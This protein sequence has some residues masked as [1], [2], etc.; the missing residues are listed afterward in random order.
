MPPAPLP[1]Q[2]PTE[3]SPTRGS[4]P[5]S[6]RLPLRPGPGSWGKDETDG[7][8]DSP[9]PL[10]ATAARHS[11]RPP[12]PQ[13][14]EDRREPSTAHQRQRG[15]GLATRSSLL[16]GLGGKKIKIREEGRSRAAPSGAEPAPGR[17][18]PASGMSTVTHCQLG[19][20]FPC[21][22]FI[23]FKLTNN[24]DKTGSSKA[25]FFFFSSFSFASEGSSDIA[26]THGSAR[27][28]PARAHAR[29]NTKTQKRKSRLYL[30]GDEV[31]P[32]VFKETFM[33]IIY[34]GAA[35]THRIS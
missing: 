3:L 17:G 9:S 12:S 10:P 22:Y 20:R 35:F 8:T 19:Q 7:R 28:P 32:I 13:G 21:V 33:C 18:T 30:T 5:T 25:I 6:P 26:Q 31:C 15:F 11:L 2:A 23:V 1:G 14:S 24:T 34:R 16:N 27:D 4:D 29:E